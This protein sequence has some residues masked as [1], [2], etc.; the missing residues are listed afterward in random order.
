M[1]LRYVVSFEKMNFVRLRDITQKARYNPWH[2]FHHGLLHRKVTDI[3][4]ADDTLL[5]ARTAQ[6]LNRLLHLLQYL[7]LSRGLHLN[8]EKCQLL[9]INPA[10]SI[11]LMDQPL[12]PCK[13]PHCKPLIGEIPPPNTLIEPVEVAKYLGSYLT[14]NSSAVQDV[15]HRYSQA[16]RCLKSLDA[17][18]RHSQISYKRKLLVHAQITLAILLFASE[19]LTYTQSQMQ[20]LNTITIHYKALRKIFS[21]QSSYYHRVLSP[22]NAECSNEYLLKLA[23]E[24]MPQLQPPSQS[25]QSSRLAYLGHLLRHESQLENYFCFNTAQNYIHF[26]QRRVGAPRIH[27]TEQVMTEAYLRYQYLLQQ[28]APPRVYDH[29]HPFYS[30]PTCQTIANTHSDWFGNTTLYRTLQPISHDRSNG[31]SLCIPDDPLKGAPC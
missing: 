2:F 25:I 26:P 15:N 5:V 16:G 22:D 6:A 31:G 14:I 19:S 12:F 11:S 4:Y 29:S 30:L 23:Y 17:F 7:A 28:Q 3:E 9:A 24:H 27:W 1:K 8:P 10:G 21:V 13:C 18:Y 20:R